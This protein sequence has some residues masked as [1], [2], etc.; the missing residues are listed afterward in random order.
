[1][2]MSGAWP[3]GVDFTSIPPELATSDAHRY[4]AVTNVA[5]E[6]TTEADSWCNQPLR[7]T[8]A[9]ETFHGPGDGAMRVTIQPGSGICRVLLQRFAVMQVTQ[10]Q[11]SPNVFPRQWTVLPSGYY[12]PEYAPIG[13][14]GSQAPSAAGQ[15]GQAIL[16]QPGYVGRRRYGFAIQVTYLHGWA[17]TSLTAPATAAATTISVDDCTLWAPINSGGFGSAGVFYDGSTQEAFNVAS[18]SAA[19]GPGTLTL[20]APLANAHDEGVLASA[21]PQNVIWGAALFAGAAALTRGA[22]ATTIRETP[23]RGS[24]SGGD[25]G[26]SGLIKQ[27][28][29]KLN[30]YRRTI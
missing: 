10:V 15:G 16:I 27:A 11:V 17:H 1:M 2:L 18:A 28:Q 22:T 4:A 24:G 9:T 25:S 26:M 3:V 5:S 13:L 12:E 23:G 30:P 21:L 14:Y 19:N 20:T 29:A 6:A 7:G 8:L